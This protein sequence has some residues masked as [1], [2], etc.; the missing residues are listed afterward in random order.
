MG[1]LSG[2]RIILGGWRGSSAG[3]PMSSEVLEI[4]VDRGRAALKVVIALARQDRS[5]I[6]GVV[7]QESGAYG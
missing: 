1:K 4:G 7:K 3:G 2:G 5:V 6:S